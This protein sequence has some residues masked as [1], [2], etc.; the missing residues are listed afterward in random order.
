VAL[1]TPDPI[2]GSYE[3]FVRLHADRFSGYLRGM[4][5][6]QAEGRGGRVP[7][8]DALQEALLQI[9][10]EWPELQDVHDDERDRR[11]YRCL[12]DAAGQALRAEH[13]R[14]DR[15]TARVRVVPFD[16]DR[17]GVGEYDELPV[18][19]RELAASVLGTMVR[20]YAD[21]EGEARAVIDRGI[22]V[23]GLRALSEREAVVLLAVDYLRWDQHALAERLGL[24]FEA[25]RKTLFEARKVFYALVRHAAG[26]DLDDEERG[27]LAAYLAGELKGPEKRA[28]RRHL[29]HC[30]ACQ[31]LQREQA[32]FG[33]DALG[34]LAPLPFLSGATVLAKRSVV[35]GSGGT[36]GAAV[37]I[38]AQPGAAKATA[39]VASVLALGLGYA[40]WLARDADAPRPAAGRA[41]PAARYVPHP[42]GMR[43]I[44]VATTGATASSTPKPPAAK[45]RRHNAARTTNASAGSTPPP[46]ATSTQSQTRQSSTN[47][48]R[49]AACRNCSGS[50]GRTSTW[51]MWPQRRSRSPIRSIARASAYH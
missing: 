35:K 47:T 29:Q 14:A 39:I 15:T 41:A 9:Y 30:K 12:R 40:A 8:D 43:R 37:G 36:G 21:G 4:L 5:G 17:L 20:D 3:D 22:L 32:V 46:A 49:P 50:G 1:T 23:A 34:L 19:E 7:V 6:R 33:R 18:R 38:F 48:S 24:G 42:P 31:G 16:F 51:R 44:T 26:L 45:R 28:A 13:G 27:R 10:E 11:L 2:E 25:M